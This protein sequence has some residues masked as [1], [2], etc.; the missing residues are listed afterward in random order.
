MPQLGESRSLYQGRSRELKAEMGALQCGLS[1][2]LL[3]VP[4]LIAGAML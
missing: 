1:V 2:L 4:K 3:A